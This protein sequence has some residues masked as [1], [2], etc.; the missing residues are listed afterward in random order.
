M[1]RFPFRYQQVSQ[2]SCKR[3][4]PQSL[5]YF[6]HIFLKLA[7]FLPISSPIPIPTM[8]FFQQKT[9]NFLHP[10]FFF[11]D[12]CLI[13]KK[14]ISSI[15]GVQRGSCGLSM[16]TVSQAAQRPGRQPEP[17][18]HPGGAASARRFPRVSSRLVSPGDTRGVREG[19]R[20]TGTWSCP[21]CLFFLFLSLSPPPPPVF[22]LGKGFSPL[23]STNRKKDAPFFL[24][25]LGI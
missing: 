14:T 5:A 4:E 10:T 20:E 21:V 18:A 12:G 15:R 9:R 11:G 17:R 19:S 25:P 7:Q 2:L 23:K 16:G 24:W 6:D 8:G 1:I 13:Q 3:C 22:F